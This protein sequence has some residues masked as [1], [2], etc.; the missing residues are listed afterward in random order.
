M[1]IRTCLQLAALKHHLT[2]N[3]VEAHSIAAPGHRPWLLAVGGSDPLLRVFD[4]RVG[5]RAG[6]IKARPRP[7]VSKCTK[8]WCNWE[9][10][11]PRHVTP[12]A[13]TCGQ[14]QR[15]AATTRRNRPAARHGSGMSAC[16]CKQLHKA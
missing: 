1:T 6:P 10:D 4:R 15:P 8:L 7:W 2:G 11:L 9:G 16:A 3:L 13:A 12:S 14:W 5:Y